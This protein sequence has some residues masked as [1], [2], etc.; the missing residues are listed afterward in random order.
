MAP[1]D[2]LTPGRAATTDP[3]AIARPAVVCFGAAHWD[4]LARA[5]AP[6]A[7]G[8]DVPG[9]VLR[10]PGGVAFNVAA[11]LAARARAVV[12]LAVVG[13]DAAGEALADAARQA[14][15]GTGHL[16]R[17]AGA[18]DTYLAIETPEGAL[19]AAVADCTALEREADALLER[20]TTACAGAAMLVIDGNLPEPVLARLPEG[21]PLALVAASPVKAARL[22]PALR[23]PGTTLYA[24]LDEAAAIVGGP[25][26]GAADAARA[27]AA[28]GLGSALITGGADAAAWLGA[29][30][31][32]ERRPPP[33]ALKS[34]T[35]AGDTLVAAHV[36]ARLRGIEDGDALE[37][38][39]AAAAA[40]VSRE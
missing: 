14:G 22:R 36:D 9:H 8:A 6:L 17:H 30:R 35:G 40:H 34:V 33:V 15:I 39:L 2:R 32:I 1:N 25:V 20:L 37:T 31:I 29:G 4:V 24:N 13:R 11:A 26:A 10:R 5:A 16:L 18:T 12:L 19:Y 27:L 38:A 21:P 3:A 23:R 7:P 28:L